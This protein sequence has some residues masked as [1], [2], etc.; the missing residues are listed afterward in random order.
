M[1][2]DEN[3]AAV[4]G[5]LCADGYVTTNLPHQKH[6]YYGIGLR[7]T[8]NTLLRDFQQKFCSVFGKKP[9]LIKN[10]RCRVYSK[11]I[12]YRLMLVGPY[13]SNNWVFPTLTKNQLKF[14]LRAF[15]D[16]EGWV[17]ARKAQDRRIAVESINRKSL[18]NIKKELK[19]KFKIPSSMYLR[20]NR[21]TAGLHIYGKDHLI[22]FQKEIGF[23]HPDKNKKLK[24]AIDSFK[25]YDWKFP[26]GKDNKKFLQTLIEKRAKVKKPH[27]IRFNSI[28]KNNISTLS[29]ELLK[30]YGVES[31]MYSRTNGNGLTYFELAIYK[32]AHVKILMKKRLLD[33]EQRAKLGAGF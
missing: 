11:E 31:K 19:E 12:Y 10:E 1:K 30:L 27:T 26:D 17:T 3:L 24:Q 6:K 20:K 23:L 22:K 7:N 13:H 16:C 29:N 21:T 18:S 4:H 15:F 14:W 28:R 2:F 5:Y 32:K 25:E 9:V 33:K 8:D